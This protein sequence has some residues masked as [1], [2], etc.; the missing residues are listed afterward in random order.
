[1]P[2]IICHQNNFELAFKQNIILKE[3]LILIAGKFSTKILGQ[4]HFFKTKRGNARL[5]DLK[6]FC[7]NK[8]KISRLDPHK[9]F[10]ICTK[11]SRNKCAA[12]ATTEGR[13]IISVGGHNHEP[14]KGKKS[15]NYC[16]E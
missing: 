5:V 8:T 16:L 3:T 4:G 11:R 12:R 2:H 9:V 7:Y 15:C 1:M 10:W 14:K 6:G 13:D